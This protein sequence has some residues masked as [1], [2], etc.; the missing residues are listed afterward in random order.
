VLIHLIF[1]CI[2]IIASVLVSFW[3]RRHYHLAKPNGIQ[4]ESQQHYYLLSLMLGLILGSF[5][6]GTANVYLS[7]KTGIAKSMLGGIAGAIF[8]AELF[9]KLN[10]IQ[11]STGLYFIPGLAVLIAVGRIGCFLAG[12]EDFTYG[13]P[14]KLPWGVN[15]GDGIKRH[16][17]QLYE[18]LSLILF[19]ISFFWFYP[20]H[21]IFW[22]RQGFY[23]FIL[24]YASQRFLWE[25]LK[26]YA[27]LGFSHLDLFQW[28]C[29]IL[30]VYAAWML[31]QTLPRS[32]DNATN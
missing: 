20:K 7:G 1:D 26:P 23:L 31:N 2:A 4:H 19:L 30:I 21:P 11:Q 15:F 29:L 12:L 25:F 28:L 3:F 13:I 6:L 5:L 18:S 24:I 14:T 16:P 27:S 17:V 8:A 22:Q 9:K 10:H 32:N